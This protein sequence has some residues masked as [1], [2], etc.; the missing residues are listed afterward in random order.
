M[1]EKVFCFMMRETF[2]DRYIRETAERVNF[3]GLVA[4]A[5]RHAEAIL[6]LDALRHAL[7]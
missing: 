5:H 1:D 4:W 6:F 3:I 7:G 2:K